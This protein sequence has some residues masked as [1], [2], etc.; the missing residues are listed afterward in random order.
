M[1]R[2]SS[3]GATRATFAGMGVLSAASADFCG[4]PVVATSPK[5]VAST[6]RSVTGRSGVDLSGSTR[7]RMPKSAANLASGGFSSVRTLSGND[8]VLESVR[9]ASSFNGA[10]STMRKDSFSG[11]PGPNVTLVIASS[12]SFASFAL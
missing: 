8:D 6:L 12:S 9:P 1:I 10:G 2:V 11:R 4:R 7:S 5:S 3:P